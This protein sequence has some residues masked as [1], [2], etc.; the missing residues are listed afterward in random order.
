MDRVP[1]LDLSNYTGYDTN[2]EFN[3]HVDYVPYWD[4]MH[5]DNTHRYEH[6]MSGD[7]AWTQ[8]DISQDA[9]MHGATFVPIILGSDKTTVTVGTGQQDYWPVYMLIRNLHNNI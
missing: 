5:T 1:E 4:F 3:D 9:C 8:D 7:W 6:L 2:P